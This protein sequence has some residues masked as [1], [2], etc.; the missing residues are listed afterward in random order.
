MLDY[1]YKKEITEDNLIAYVT[2]QRVTRAIWMRIYLNASYEVMPDIE[3]LLPYPFATNLICKSSPRTID[4]KYT[5]C[6][7]RTGDSIVKKMI[8]VLDK[9]DIS[10]DCPS[11]RRLVTLDRS[12]SIGGEFRPRHPI[13]DDEFF[14]RPPIT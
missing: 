1:I 7:P 3:Y 13:N 9:Y 12:F 6:A 10:Y 14:P 2:I 5:F 8:E 11:V 4:V